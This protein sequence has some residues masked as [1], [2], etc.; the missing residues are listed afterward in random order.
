MPRRQP[1]EHET[2]QPWTGALPPRA[3]Q[4]SDAVR[5]LLNDNWK[6]RL[7][8]T[9]AVSDAFAASTFDDKSWDKIPVPSHWNLQDGKYGLP[10]YQN[11]K[12]PFPVDAPYVPTENPTGDYRYEFDLGSWSKEGSV[13]L[14]TA[15]DG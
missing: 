7:S 9:A 11:I 2:L 3:W 10:A 4:E 6:F 13:S 12:F 5:V 1:L 14:S 15:G 8:A